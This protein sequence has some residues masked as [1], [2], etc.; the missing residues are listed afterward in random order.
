MDP[1]F[2]PNVLTAGEKQ[3]AA[4]NNLSEAQMLDYKR[5]FLAMTDEEVAAA[6]RTQSTNP[7]LLG[8][9][10]ESAAVQLDA[11]DLDMCKRLGVSPEAYL[12]T[13]REQ[14]ARGELPAEPAQQRGA[15]A[16]AQALDAADLEACRQLGVR[17]EQYAASKAAGGFNGP[18]GA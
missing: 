11:G 8:A 2:N 12:Q 17:P 18:A 6:T 3:N 5:A 10:L 13:K 9:V 7:Y 1:K 16:G 15:P 4:A 14:V